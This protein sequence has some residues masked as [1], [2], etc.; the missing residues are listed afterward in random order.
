M[1]EKH[2]KYH[3]TKG[4]DAAFFL[5]KGKELGECSFEIMGRILESR[6]F[7]EQ[8]YNACLGL[9]RLSDHLWERPHGKCLQTCN[10]FPQGELPAD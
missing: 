4:W 10:G 3:E 1:P 7:T 9:L 2:K 8:A 5:K 6:T